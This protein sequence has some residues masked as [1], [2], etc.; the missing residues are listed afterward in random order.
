M[1]RYEWRAGVL[2]GREAVRL[3]GQG[4]WIGETIHPW[5]QLTHVNFARYQTRGG[6]NEVLT[7]WFGPDTRRALRWMGQARTRG[8]WREMLVA[9]AQMAARQRPDL[10]VADGPDAQA[11]QSARWIGLGVAGIALSVTA[12][13][14][15]SAASIYGMLA[16][17]W[18]GVVG[19]VVGGLIY[20]FYDRLPEPPRLAWLSFAEREGQEGE[21]PP[22]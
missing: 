5:S 16:G 20:K 9:F 18:I 7:L 22:N 1:V 21:L 8:P 13:V 14:F 4:I 19:A 17:A 15:A 6:V 10:T 12:V 11:Q 3:S 2:D